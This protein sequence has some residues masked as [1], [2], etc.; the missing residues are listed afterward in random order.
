MA[1]QRSD[2]RFPIS[3]SLTLATS[4]GLLVA[5]AVGVVFWIQWTTAKRTT[6][7]LVV[8]QVNLIADKFS[9]KHGPYSFCEIPFQ[10]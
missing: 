10:N 6:S 8:Q 1:H 9:V 7:E 5:V 3:I 4:I 2:A